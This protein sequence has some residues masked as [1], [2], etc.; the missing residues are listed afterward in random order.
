MQLTIKHSQDPMSIGGPTFTLFTRF[1][2]DEEEKQLV[3]RYRVRQTVLVSGDNE[4][5]LNRAFKFGVP[6]AI[7]VAGI[8]TIAASSMYTSYLQILATPILI[9]GI[10]Y[11]VVAYLIYHALREDVRV[12]DVLNGR[13]FRARDV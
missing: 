1:E 12:G 2:L 5:A 3:D 11:G 8:V 4:R 6:I 9:F 7:V 13:T 10:A